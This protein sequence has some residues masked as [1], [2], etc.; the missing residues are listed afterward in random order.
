M[1]VWDQDLIGADDAIG[2]AELNLG[3]MLSKARDLARS[4]LLAQCPLLTAPPPLSSSA[5]LLRSPPRL[6]QALKKRAGQKQNGMWIEC[7]HP[8]FKG[9]QAKARASIVTGP[10]LR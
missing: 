2:E 6:S 7:S 10:E 5:L 8:N 4:P 1:Q 9:T 3:P